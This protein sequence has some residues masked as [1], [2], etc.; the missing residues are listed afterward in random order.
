MYTLVYFTGFF[1]E[2]MICYVYFAQLKWSGHVYTLTAVSGVKWL[3]KRNSFIRAQ[4]KLWL[5]ILHSPGILHFS[6]KL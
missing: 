6:E 1:K 5:S 3:N 4:I 2:L